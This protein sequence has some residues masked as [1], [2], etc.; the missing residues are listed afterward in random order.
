MAPAPLV[1]ELKIQNYESLRGLRIKNGL[2]VSSG[3]DADYED[4]EDDHR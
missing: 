1:Y 2:G 3:W 4:G